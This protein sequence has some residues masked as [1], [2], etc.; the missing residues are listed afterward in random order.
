MRVAVKGG[1]WHGLKQLI[2]L[3][4]L[5]ALLVVLATL[6]MPL[7]NDYRDVIADKI[8]TVIRHPLKIGY[9]D[10]RWEGFKLKP[11]VTF[12]DVDISDPETG[13][14]I[15]H[16]ARMGIRVNPWKSLLHRRLEADVI[17]LSGSHFKV[18]RG[19]DHKISVQGFSGGGATKRPSL[20]KIL[21]RVSGMTLKLSDI[22]IE[23]DD[24]IAD[25]RYRF[26]AAD[27]DLYVGHDALALK[28]QIVPPRSLGDRIEV[29]LV[30]EGPLDSPRQWNSHYFVAG[31]EINLAGV[32]YL[33]Q[34]VL[35][36]A[37]SGTLDLKLWGSS[38]RDS[39]FDVQGSIALHDVR[40][41]AAPAGEKSGSPRFG[42]IDEL[43]ADLR[44]SGDF[45]SWR[46]DM[47]RLRVI[48]PQKHWPEGGFSLAWDHDV[49]AYFG[50]VDY[51]DIESVR[52]IATLMPG[53]TE[54]QLKWLQRLQPV[55]ELRDLDFSLP[56]NFDSLEKFAF[57]A[58]FDALG[59]E[60]M[61]RIPGVSG[62]SGEV[63]ATAEQGVARID[64][65]GFEL[66]YPR[67]FPE[68]IDVRSIHADLNW[69]KK[70]GVWEVSLENLILANDDIVA[71]GGG[72]LELGKGQRYPVLTLEL[73]APSFPLNRVSHYVPYKIVP[74]KTGQWLRRAFDAGQAKNI[75]M[76]YSGP[77]RKAAFKKG[78][79]KMHVELEVDGASLEYHRNWPALSGLAG[80]VRFDNSRMTARVEQGEVMGASI[81]GADVEIKDLFRARLTVKGKAQGT[82][83][84]ALQFV[85]NSPLN[86]NLDDFLDRVTSAGPVELDLDLLLTLTK[87]LKKIHRA[88]GTIDLR[89]CEVAI[90][91]QD[92]RVSELE[93]RLQFVNSHFSAESLRGVFRN[94]PVTASVATADDGTVQVF[95]DGVW[96]PAD[97]LP[98]QRDLIEPVT[99]GVAVWHGVINLPHR[100]PGGEKRAP[101][102]EVRSQLDGVAIELPPPL[103]KS[104]AAKRE[105]AVEY[106][107]SRPPRLRVRVPRLFDVLAE[108]RTEPSLAVARADVALR[109]DATTL[110]ASGIRLHGE[111]PEVDVAAWADVIA[112]Y[113]RRDE[114]AR[115]NLLDR[116]NDID[117]RIG[118]VLVAGQ[119]F[120]NV[121]LKAKRGDGRWAC[122]IDAP[123]IAGNVVVPLPLGREPVMARLDHLVLEKGRSRPARDFDPRTLPP[124]EVQSASLRWGER[125]FRDFRL[126]SAPKADGMALSDIAL[127]TDYLDVEASGFWRRTDSSVESS[128]FQFVARGKDV[129][130][131]LKAFDFGESLGSGSGS[132]SGAVSWPG[133]PAAYSLETLRADLAVDLHDGWLRKIDPGLGRLIGLLSLDYLPRRLALNFKDMEKE[134]FYYEKLRGS[135]RIEA[136]RLT[137]DDLVI[138][139]PVA[140]FSIEGTTHLL[141]RHYDLTL[142]VVPKLSSSAPLAAG[143]IAGPQAGVVVFMLDKLAEG[144]GIDV[145][146]T[147]ALDYAVTGSWD[148]PKITALRAEG[149]LSDDESVFEVME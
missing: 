80:V 102:L 147:I 145:N 44:L 76:N 108:M 143:L 20:E 136:G 11:L 104:A 37:G 149:E 135:A 55:G 14:P 66:D 142:Q 18:V 100:R 26:S 128:R 8:A 65:T 75:R 82:L 144:M 137:I 111:W 43:A 63:L 51:V 40:V 9:I 56:R 98:R 131:I 99:Q 125:L 25:R 31:S 52:T 118:N 54:R 132:L 92:V 126:R 140:S 22:L 72:T 36:R 120:A 59:W 94:A 124:L 57:K 62:I 77:L 114:K 27:L 96:R 15:L 123:G 10:A 58:R 106:H 35:S 46:I 116:V 87:K 4:I 113:P 86:R 127:A 110:P 69:Q 121:A 78:E 133:S 34:G 67:L 41:D 2:S 71:R 42:F 70:A 53:L 3:L 129:G 139:G 21:D 115:D 16:F 122:D 33:R 50:V 79:A 130:E 47:D 49:G 88:R 93:G 97:L 61:D 24:R 48:T 32:P 107:F 81:R 148:E 39:G 109:G 85:K 7:A 28:A 12:R 13:Q 95:V 23:W 90:S 38:F 141:E 146:K 64:S 138:D 117:L 60:E 5:L 89:R 84:Q 112:R 17:E 101:W 74:P 83:P 29:Q 30:A 45:R 134:G 119:E 103:G 73:I 1:V 68:V 6:L 105:L 19:L 91:A